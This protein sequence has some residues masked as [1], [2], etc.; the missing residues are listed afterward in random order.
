MGSVLTDS[1]IFVTVAYKFFRVSVSLPRVFTIAENY[2]FQFR[3]IKYLIIKPSHE[4][5]STIVDANQESRLMPY[6]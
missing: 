1:M 4:T 6:F 2:D 5:Y 3:K